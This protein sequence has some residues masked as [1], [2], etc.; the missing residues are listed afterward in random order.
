MAA[1]LRSDADHVQ[2]AGNEVAQTTAIT[3]VGIM[4]AITLGNKPTHRTRKQALA[5]LPPQRLILTTQYVVLAI[6]SQTTHQ[7]WVASLT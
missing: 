3:Y 7:T 4:V 2:L 5:F 6:S 1:I